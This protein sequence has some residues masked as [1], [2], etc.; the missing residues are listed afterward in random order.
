VIYNQAMCQFRRIT[1]GAS[2]IPQIDGLRFVAIMSVLLTHLAT[3]VRVRGPHIVTIATSGPL[4]FFNF[5]SGGRGVWLF[6]AIS[7]FI[8]ARPFLRQ[9]RL[10]GH[11]V[12][13]QK[14]FLRRITRLEPPYN[15]S[16]L[17][18]VLAAFLMFPIRP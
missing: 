17:L 1:S 4:T 18:Y 15:L 5:S 8:L 13:L 9:H 6:F 10:G 12:Q 11:P 3:E 14:Y 16:L 2:W 7:G